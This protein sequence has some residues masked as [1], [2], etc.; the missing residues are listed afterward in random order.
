MVAPA[1]ST[2]PIAAVQPATPRAAVTATPTPQPAGLGDIRWSGEEVTTATPVAGPTQ[3][4]TDVPRIIANVP[5]YSL[6]AGSQVSAAWSYNDTSLDAF[7]TTLTI[8]QLQ[9]E[10]WLAFQLSRNAETPWPAGVYQITI[11]LNGQAAQTSS[12]E[13]IP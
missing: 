9:A 11:S 3:L 1:T 4:T 10:Q 7:A 8:D 6:A 13:V 2:P 12:I 5:A